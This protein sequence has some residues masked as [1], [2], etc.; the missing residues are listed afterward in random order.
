[1]QTKVYAINVVDPW[2]QAGLEHSPGS[3]QGQNTHPTIV[4]H[5]PRKTKFLVEWMS[6]RPD[7][8]C[9]FLLLA[10]W[11]TQAGQ[12]PHLSNTGIEAHSAQGRLCGSLK[13]R[14][15]QTTVL[16]GDTSPFRRLTQILWATQREKGQVF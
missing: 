9:A 7:G 10:R 12:G 2:P 16:V 11:V 4:R 5:T 15:A 1:M 14:Q 13:E 6:V 3:L 8:L